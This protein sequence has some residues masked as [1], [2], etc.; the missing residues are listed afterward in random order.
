MPDDSKVT[1]YI[2]AIK[3]QFASGHARE[4]AY[5]P[6]L[7]RLMA[8]FEDVTA[9]ND[10]KRSQHGNPDFVFVKK[11]NRNITFGY[12]EAKDITTRLVKTIN[13]EQLRR[14]A[15]YEKLFLTNYLDFK[16]FRNGE[17]YE[18]VS[19][20][21]I[22]G[23]ELSLT[24]NSFTR[25]QDV[26]QEFLNQPPET[27]KSG[28]RLAI[29]MGGKA[30]RIRDNVTIYLGQ[31]TSER[32]QELEKIFKMMKTLLV[33]DLTPE[34]FA[35]MY[36]Q[37]LVYGLFVARYN[38]K[39]SESFTRSE[40]R[41][42]V[43][44]S[45]PFLREFF[46]HIVG[47]RFD[48][49]LSHIVDELCEVFSVSGVHGLVQKHLKLFEEDNEKDPIIHFYEDF[50]KEYDPAERK[51]M[52]AYYTPIPIVRFI[53]RQVD[54]I[55]KN[56]FGLAKGIADSSKRQVTVQNQG[57]KHKIDMHRV[58]ILD[59]A[60]GTAT[61][62]NEIIQYIHKSFIGQEGRWPAYAEQDLLPRLHGFEL[63]MAPYTIAHLKLGMTLQDAGVK[64]STQR[65]GVYLT[66][67][68][69]EGQKDQ[70]DLF[71][72]FGLAEIVS[73]EADEAAK[74]KHERPIMVVMGNPPYSG[75]SYN[76]T[77]YANSLIDKYKFEPGG[78]TPLKEPNSKWLYND[79]V[80]FIGF[81]EDMVVKNGEG[82]IAM[83]TD[84]SYLE[85][86]VFRGMRWRLAASFD[87]IYILD[88]HGNVRKKEIS[89]D[90]SKDENVFDIAQGVSII[91]AVKNSSSNKLADIYHSDIHGK[92]KKKFIQL[93]EEAHWQ[94]IDLDARN[95]YFIPKNV[96]GKTE[97]GSGIA[98]NQLFIESGNGIVT[99][100]DNLAIQDSPEK[101]LAAAEDIVNLSK[102]EFYKKYNL[103]EDV[104]DWRYNW[105]REDVLRDGPNE[106]LVR[107]INYRPFDIRFIYYTGRARGFIGWP[108]QKIMKNYIDNNVGLVV[109]RMTKGKPFAHVFITQKISEAIFLSPLTGTN[110]YNFPL[111]LYHDDGTRTVNF[112]VEVL[113]HLT[114]NLKNH[115][116]PEDILNYIYAVL[117]SPAYRKKYKHF[118][119]TDF[120]QVPVPQSD[121]GFE[122][123]ADFGKRLQ[124]LH[125]MTSQVAK[126][127][128]TTFPVAGSDE[129]KINPRY[130]N[131]KVWINDS[132]YFGAVPES[133]WNFNIGGYQPAQ[134]WLKDR[135]GQ[136]LSNDDVEHYQKIIKV[137]VKTDKLMKE[138]DATGFM[139]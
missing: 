11:S 95:I 82:I 75:E 54:E 102:E 29:I 34:K 28:K 3:E 46:D 80:K 88:L 130:D 25:L 121:A 117:H 138:I 123:L 4:H 91:L 113:K 128:I 70:V 22:N 77:S 7:E 40:A 127:F 48:A 78:Q 69:E 19:I 38:D 72:Q 122:R 61:F 76:K 42:L 37:T 132:Q 17:E 92:R 79:Y 6:A 43:P 109:S 99:K 63:M 94:K 50:L 26:L 33:H 119:E 12:A 68:L 126:D 15:G 86:L 108:V 30:R 36:S 9:V 90:G 116:E 62:L 125:L 98:I 51:K 55:L 27:I 52:G 101:A 1:A 118:L 112:R 13:T 104:R 96:K 83:I 73:K 97:Y 49:R 8:G 74:I 23:T 81:A 65:L 32:N 60:V 134:K 57:T 135:K 64:D 45:N 89:P 111:W 110:A 18:E 39:T 66:N 107:E 20:G 115:Y 131:E 137:L 85:G 44:A 24:P 67:T 21:K 84:N 59:P 14:Y 31:E 114:K 16:F 129:V 35:D 71:T 133:A 100:R 2:E 87:K 103:P 124:E 41:D 105:A 10:P 53:V 139:E 5:R 56:E 120:P 47:P 106:G 136:K 58:Q 93:N